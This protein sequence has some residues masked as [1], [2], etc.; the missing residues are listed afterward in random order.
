MTESKIAGN[1][2][3]AFGIVAMGAAA[4]LMLDIYDPVTSGVFHR[5]RST[6]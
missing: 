2:M 3:A 4:M 1:K 5:A 6:I